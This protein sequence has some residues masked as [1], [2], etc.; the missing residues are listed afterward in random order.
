M[1]VT[2]R[3]ILFAMFGQVPA[4]A[5]ARLRALLF[6]YEIT[7]SLAVV[8][9][10][11]IADELRAGPLAAEELARRTAS[12]PDA[13]SRVL[14]ALVAVGVFERTEDGRFRQN[15]LSAHLCEDARP[16]LRHLAMLFGGD[17][18]T[19]WASA[20][21][22]VKTGEPVFAKVFGRDHFSYIA[23]HPAS[24]ETFTK[25]M[26]GTARGSIDALMSVDW[27]STRHVVDVGGGDGTL[28]V[29]LLEQQPSLE[30]TVFDLPE[31]ETSAIARITQAGLAGRCAFRG[32]SFITAPPPAADAY[33]LARVL[34]DWNDDDAR[35]ILERVRGASNPGARVLIIDEI[36][37]S[38]SE[39]ENGKLLDLQM[40]VILGGRERTEAEWSE[41]LS[42]SGFSVTSFRRDPRWSLVEAR[43]V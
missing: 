26:A 17:M 2:P 29:A 16:S 11:G 12:H 10:L 42:S 9:R 43:A 8:A 33:V 27:S 19:A 38:G 39:Y 28:L 40:L 15:E 4:S 13:L 25:A 7:Q 5:P 1:V 41:L 31:V 32:G 35:G 21:E 23:D 36:L 20:I 30:G 6:G 14:R 18:Y 37:S 24:L 22:S 3:H 34:H